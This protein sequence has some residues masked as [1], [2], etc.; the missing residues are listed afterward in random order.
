MNLFEHIKKFPFIVAPLAG[1]TDYPFRKLCR[2]YGASL[3]YTEMVSEFTM[4]TPRLRPRMEKLTY[5][6]QEEKPVGIQLFGNKAD[7]FYDAAKAAEEMGFDIIDINFGCPVRKVAG[8]G[9]GA[10]LLLDLPLAEKIVQ[11]TV[12]AVKIPVSIKIRSGW[13]DKKDVYLEF[14]KMAEDNGVSAITL[15]PRTRMQMF[16]GKSNWE[17]IRLL[18][19]KSKLFV[20]GN[21]DVTNSNE[22]HRMIKETGCDAVMIGRAAIGNPF[23]F[24]EIADDTYSPTLRERIMTSARHFE[25]LYIL[26]SR[27]GMLEARK[28]FNKYLKGFDRASDVRQALMKMEDRDEILNFLKN[29]PEAQAMEK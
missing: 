4:A 12:K 27:F 1:Y 16:K 29:M 26:K 24:K 11:N 25:M 6:S 19:E 17:H 10:S 2:E 15:H 5:F 3:A 22:A 28:Y 21:G 8:S 7:M 23:I 14:N 9:S 20:I 18:K 13:D